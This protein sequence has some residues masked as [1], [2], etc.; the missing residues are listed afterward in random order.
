MKRQIK[1]SSGIIVQK[2]TIINNKNRDLLGA[3]IIN[4]GG[5]PIIFDEK[6]EIPGIK[7]ASFILFTETESV[8]DNQ[9][10]KIQFKNPDDPNNKIYLSIN[11]GVYIEDCH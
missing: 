4:L 7:D 1:R 9:D 10:T 8:Y 5:T 2:Q 3:T 6:L 11:R